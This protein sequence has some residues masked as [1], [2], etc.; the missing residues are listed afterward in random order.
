MIS[1]GPIQPL[2]CDYE[3]IP[4]CFKDT[5]IDKVNRVVL[6]IV[7][8]KGEA[9]LLVVLFPPSLGGKMKIKVFVI[10][11]VSSLL[12]GLLKVNISVYIKLS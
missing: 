1:K 8:I 10:L 7:K 9:S 5:K 12:K 4:F 3:K 2:C 6:V 11:Q